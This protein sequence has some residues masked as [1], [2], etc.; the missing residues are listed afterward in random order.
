MPTHLPNILWNGPRSPEGHSII[1]FITR[2]PY[3]KSFLS[4]FD[5]LGRK[6]L[7][8]VCNGSLHLPRNRF[9]RGSARDALWAEALAREITDQ[10]LEG[11]RGP[12]LSP[13]PRFS[14]DFPSPSPYYGWDSY[15][16]KALAKL[17]GLPINSFGSTKQ[18]QFCRSSQS[19]PLPSLCVGMKA[20]LRPVV[21]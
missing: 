18:K 20:K 5:K 9:C 7:W 19:F 14:L 6:R 15:F 17:V 2:N 8:R 21:F 13:T 16:F 12:P 4:G 1:T 10:A 3:S 11:A